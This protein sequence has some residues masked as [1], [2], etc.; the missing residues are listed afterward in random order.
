M[1]FDSL[2]LIENTFSCTKLVSR[3]VVT[4]FHMIKTQIYNFSVYFNLYLSDKYTKKNFFVF[5]LTNLFS[6]LETG[7]ADSVGS[8]KSH[9]TKTNVV[10]YNGPVVYPTFMQVM[11][12]WVPL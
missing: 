7:F 12:S 9:L 8:P 10:L 6:F 3:K 1:Q 5:S 2:K 4:F 11:F